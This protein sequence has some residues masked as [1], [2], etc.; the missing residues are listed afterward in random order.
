MLM[1]CHMSI[2]G[3]SSPCIFN[4]IMDNINNVRFEG[5][6]AVTMKNVAFWNVAPCSFCLNRRF[7]GTYLLHF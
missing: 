4:N 2:L 1:S 7:G 6:T 5:F 3:H